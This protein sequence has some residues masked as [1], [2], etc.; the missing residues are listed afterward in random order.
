MPGSFTHHGGARS[1]C[2]RLGVQLR[3]RL[4]PLNC[5]LWADHVGGG[6]QLV[7]FP[8]HPLP[9]GVKVV[10]LHLRRRSVGGWA[11]CKNGVVG[12]MGGWGG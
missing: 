5:Q 4:H 10:P 9:Q 3:H 12:R 8:L 6:R 2:R 11:D 1:C 7:P